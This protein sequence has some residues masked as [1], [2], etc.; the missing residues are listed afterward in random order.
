MPCLTG[1]RKSFVSMPVTA[2]A[3]FVPSDVAGL[4]LWLDAGL[5]TF[6]NAAAQFTAANSESLSIADNASLSTGDIDFT[7]E[8]WFRTDDNSANYC[9]ASR[10]DDN[11]IALREWELVYL[12]ASNLIQFTVWDVTAV[13]TR[14]ASGAA[15]QQTWVHVIGEHNAA[16]NTVRII[17]N[18]GTPVS[19][20]CPNGPADIIIQTLIGAETDVAG[21]SK[22]MNGRIGPVRF[23]KRTLTAGEITSLYNSGLGK[24]HADLTTA[25]KVSMEGSWNLT[26]ASGNRADSQGSNTLTDN[27]TVTQAGGIANNAATSDGDPMSLW[28][29][30]TANN[31]DVSQATLS[32]RP[33]LKLAIV[34][35][36]SVVRFDGVDDY[37]LSSAFAVFPAKRGTVFV[38]YD[39]NSATYGSVVGTYSGAAVDWHLLGAISG[40]K[41]KWNDGV[42]VQA[43]AAFDTG[44]FQLTTIIRDGDTT[45]KNRVGGSLIDTFTVTDNQPS[46]AAMALGANTAGA[47][48]LTGDIAELLI[49]DSALSD[50]NRESVESYLTTKYAI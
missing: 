41:H 36:K 17:I 30:Q 1:I 37:L 40:T 25:E 23:W 9:I 13:T 5:G 20:A 45:V 50:A 14:N 7:V 48:S 22:H 24:L 12:G 2:A 18:D 16:A 8:A 31:N 49:Y 11:T 10:F 39:N 46:S 38:V 42:T 19:T 32:K 4:K 44:A 29:D 43:S 15:S 3:A 21:K 28:E 27:N 34:N 26:E 35:G 6:K 33:T 47:E